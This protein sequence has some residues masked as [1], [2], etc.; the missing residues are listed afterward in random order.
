MYPYDER[1][2][3]PPAPVIEVEVTSRPGDEAHRVLMQLDSGSDI[4]CVPKGVCDKL[5]AT[6]FGRVNVRGYSGSFREAKTYFFNVG[7]ARQM[8]SHVEMLPIEGT[9]GLIGRDVLNEISVCF[10]G[11]QLLWYISD[12]KSA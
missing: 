8:F 12:G 9:I 5:V 4:S 2:F 3:V 11:R 7:F 1:Q 10:D 6:R